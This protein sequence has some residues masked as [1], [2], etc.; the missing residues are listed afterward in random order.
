MVVKYNVKLFKLYI[1]REKADSAV[2]LREPRQGVG[3]LVASRELWFA[4]LTAEHIQKKALTKVSAFFWW[5]E[6]DSNHRS[7]RRQIY[8]L[9]HL[10]TLQSAQ[11]KFLPRINGVSVEL[12]IGIEPTTC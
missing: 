3:N 11:I 5:E 8:S 9:M 7:R 10:A 2:S 1:K 4:I 6:V 12:V